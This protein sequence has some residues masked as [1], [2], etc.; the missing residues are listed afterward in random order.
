MLT[1]QIGLN[2]LEKE[3]D[4]KTG[5]EE[6]EEHRIER[7]N[8]WMNKEVEHM[9]NEGIIKHVHLNDSAGKDDDHNLIG[10]GILDVHTLRETL[11]KAGYEE[12]LIIE[13]G[14]RGA[15]S[16]QHLLNAYDVFN[17]SLFRDERSQ[18]GF[19]DGEEGYRIGSATHQDMVSMNSGGN[20]Q[21]SDWMSVKREYNRRPEY[22]AYGMSP[23]SFSA[24]PQQGQ[25][26]GGWSNTSFF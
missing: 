21:V 7:F 25:Q 11:R 2:I 3:I 17:V 18:G 10:Q 16:N 13:A 6:T 22:S 9:Y 8:N 5:R 24:Q 4:P 23:S 1:L 15:N 19:V 20:M 12:A 14:G 26:V